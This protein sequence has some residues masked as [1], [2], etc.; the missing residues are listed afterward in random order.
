M[1]DHDFKFAGIGKDDFMGRAILNYA[2]LLTLDTMPTEDGW[3]LLPDDYEMTA[4][5]G[6]FCASKRPHKDT[7]KRTSRQ[8][9]NFCKTIDIDPISGH[10]MARPIPFARLEFTLMTAF[11]LLPANYDRTSDPYI[12]I[13]V[14]DELSYRITKKGY[15]AESGLGRRTFK[16]TVKNG[17]LNPVW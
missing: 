7:T 16:T 2:D 10:F 5:G 11:N 12:K 8:A 14:K 6:I 4:N 17:T 9:W 13:R 1:F 15:V 3:P